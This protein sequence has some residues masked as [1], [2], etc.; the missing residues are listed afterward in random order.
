MKPSDSKGFRL[1]LASL[2]ALACFGVGYI[3]PHNPV[4]LAQSPNPGPSLDNVPGGVGGKGMALITNGQT[5]ETINQGKGWPCQTH[6][7]CTLDFQFRMTA[8]G[9][10]PPPAYGCAGQHK[11]CLT[12]TGDNFMIQSEDRTGIHPSAGSFEQVNIAGR[13]QLFK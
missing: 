5:L 1:L 8:H 9:S 7:K 2:F 6:Q 13:L 11:N 3:V 10:A 12:F 4:A